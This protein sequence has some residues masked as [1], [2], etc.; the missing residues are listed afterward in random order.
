MNQPHRNSNWNWET[1]FTPT[2][3]PQPTSCIHIFTKWLF[4]MGE[5]V[6]QTKIT[7][8]ESGNH[9]IK[10]EGIIQTFSW[11]YNRRQK[12][13]NV[14]MSVCLLVCFCLFICLFLH[15]IVRSFVCL[16]NCLSVCFFV[17]LFVR[18]FVCL[19]VCL[20]VC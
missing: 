8:E 13:L 15:L 18:V 7:W 12:C 3:H 10:R 1:N 20:L 5:T 11:H 6:L 9:Q 16:Y 14:W 2:G 4:K 19:L 17:W